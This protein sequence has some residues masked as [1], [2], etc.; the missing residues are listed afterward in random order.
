MNEV[1]NSVNMLLWIIIRRQITYLMMF[2][3]L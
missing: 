3:I 2:K 1:M